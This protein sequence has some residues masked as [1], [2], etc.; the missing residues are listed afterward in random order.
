MISQQEVSRVEDGHPVALTVPVYAF[1]FFLGLFFLPMKA[2][3]F[4][5][6]DL[7]VYPSYLVILALA[8][9]NFKA[10][11]ETYLTFFRTPTLVLLG[12]AT[13]DYL[14]T[15]FDFSVFLF[16]FKIIIALMMAASYLRLLHHDEYKTMRFLTWG[17]SVSVAFMTY[18]FLSMTLFSSS[19][20]F[21]SI[22]QFEIGRGLSTRFGVNRVTGFTEEPS[23][24]AVMLIGSFFLLHSYEQ[25]SGASQK[26]IKLTTVLGMLLCTSDNLLAT[27]PLLLIFSL[28]Y[29]LRLTWLFFVLFY[30]ANLAIYP[31]IINLDSSFFARFSS[32]SI[33]AAEPFTNQLLG[34]GFN[35]YNKLNVIQY[36]TPLGVPDLIV[37]S[38]GSLWGGLLLE[39]GIVFTACFCLY[40]TRLVNGAKFG[41]GYAL[42]AILIMLANYYS[43]WWPITSFALAYLLHSRYSFAGFA[44]KEEPIIE[45]LKTEVSAE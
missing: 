4:S 21:T 29:R 22:S 7:A 20:P 14:R 15:G 8:A 28:L 18:Q 30:V 12:F 2:F 17:I 24:I 3:H 27:L 19:L 42:M 9:V 16:V 1:V 11:I 6:G 10:F 38:L 35:Q 39:G 31:R 23:Y 34:I 25:R 36:I 37:D 41:T 44:S 32:Y 45:S 40:I 5:L 33:F 43:P 26:W 13:L